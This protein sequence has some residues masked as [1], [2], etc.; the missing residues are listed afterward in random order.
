MSRSNSASVG[1][2]EAGHGLYTRRTVFVALGLMVAFSGLLYLEGRPAWFKSGLAFWSP[3]WTSS[4][5]QNFLDPYSLSHVLHGIIFYWLLRPLA[6][7]CRCLGG[8]S[9]RGTGDRMGSAGEFA[10]GD[11]AL[12]AR[13]GSVR[14][15]RRQHSSMRW[16]TCWPAVVGFAI[17]SRFSWKVSVALFVVFELWML[18]LARDN[19]TL[20]VL[21]LF[22]PIEAIKE[23][24]LCGIRA[25]RLAAAIRHRD[26]QSRRRS[27]SRW[28][29]RRRRGGCCG[30][31]AAAELVGHQRRDAQ[32]NEVPCRKFVFARAL[33]QSP[34]RPA[35]AVPRVVASQPPA[36]RRRPTCSLRRHR[37]AGELRRTHVP[38][39]PHWPQLWRVAN[40]TI[41]NLPP[42]N[43]AMAISAVS[44]PRT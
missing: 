29:A 23:W 42:T 14:L 10:L 13:D 35:W 44:A 21:M 9:S 17:A 30:P 41:R 3:A 15:Y 7:A 24:Q 33:C 39:E 26:R 8:W 20:N 25:A 1:M 40:S 37:S 28:S 36:P 2:P 4:T 27:G 11:R 16:A 19:L 31:A 43:A 22:Y 18:W 38:V 34:R 6:T 5:S 32:P 12:S